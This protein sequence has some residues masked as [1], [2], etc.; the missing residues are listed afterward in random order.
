M[1]I[2]IDLAQA[3]GSKFDVPV[4]PV[5]HLEAHAFTVR[6]EQANELADASEIEAEFPFL[7]VIVTGKHT[8]IVLTRGVGLHTILGFTVDLACG[9]SIDRFAMLLKESLRRNIGLE[10][11]NPPTD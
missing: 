4:I 5:N 11:D 10:L 3:I 9:T 8:E 7:S 1:R 2:G 6:M